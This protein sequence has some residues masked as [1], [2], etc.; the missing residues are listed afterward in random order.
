[1]YGVKPALNTDTCWSVSLEQ[2]KKSLSKG[3]EVSLKCFI[4]LCVCVCWINQAGNMER[5]QSFKILAV[6]C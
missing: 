5:A 4:S 2:S 3:Q 6:G 1:M